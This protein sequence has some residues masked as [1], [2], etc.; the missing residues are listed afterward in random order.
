VWVVIGAI[1][2]LGIVFWPI[3]HPA[4]FGGVR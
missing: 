3:L 2:V 4:L 1:V